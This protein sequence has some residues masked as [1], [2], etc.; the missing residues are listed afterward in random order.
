MAWAASSMPNACW[1]SPSGTCSCERS[2]SACPVPNVPTTLATIAATP[3]SSALPRIAT[4]SPTA[5]PRFFA[6]TAPTYA[7]RGPRR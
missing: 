5:T 4:S 3:P 1:K 7:S 2:K 6:S